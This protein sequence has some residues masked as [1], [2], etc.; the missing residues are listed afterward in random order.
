MSEEESKEVFISYAR[1]AE[2]SLIEELKS[3]EEG[4]NVLY[5]EN[6]LKSNG[7]IKVLEKEIGGAEYIIILLSK[8][9][10]QSRHCMREL[11]YLY[12]KGAHKLMPILVFVEGSSP[13]DI[14]ESEIIQYWENENDGEKIVEM[15]PLY[16]AW[17]LGKYDA[18]TK[19]YDTLFTVL[20]D[21][22]TDVCAKVFK[23]LDHPR[24]LRY[25]HYS[26]SGKIEKIRIN[27]EREV[28]LLSNENAKTLAGFLECS[29]DDIAKSFSRILEWSDVTKLFTALEKWLKKER[30]C[31]DT[32]KEVI[33]LA[34][35]ARDILGWFL[36]T[37]IDDVKITILIHQM[38]HMGESAVLELFED[39]DSG[40][41]VLVSAI[42]CSP[43]TFMLKENDSGSKLTGKGELVLPE[44][45][46][47][48]ENTARKVKN[49]INYK[50]LYEG[51]AEQNKDFSAD[52]KSQDSAQAALEG[53]FGKDTYFLKAKASQL[54][55]KSNEVQ[56]CTTLGKQFPELTLI[57]L[58]DKD[59][60]AV[61]Q[62]Y[63]R[64]GLKIGA[65]NEY[66]IDIYKQ[67][68]EITQK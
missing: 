2:R 5:D 43:V 34:G 20:S 13:E 57:A 23:A 39:I 17:L 38:N 36:L 65:L 62:Q 64:S 46:M 61:V 60:Q 9:Y 18:E 27:I 15:I 1:K 58:L 66:I 56:I 41:Q 40:F 21:G 45:G 12:E 29:S 25:K 28:R 47:N 14:Q 51:L 63:M 33:R 67:I 16:L 26:V 6:S 37:V 32:S 49:D 22:G 52:P 19:N 30:D 31:N 44:G 10:F 55:L 24:K 3:S 4:W 42:C 59:E 8:E 53:R 54:A 48:D 50:R 11:R 35:V 7:S 68:E